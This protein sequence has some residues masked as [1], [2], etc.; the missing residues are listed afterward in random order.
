MK[1]IIWA[2]LILCS[3][4]SST[5]AETREKSQII[6]HS[7]WSGFF[8]GARIAASQST[9]N[10]KNK[11]DDYGAPTLLPSPLDW[12]EISKSSSG[13]VVEKFS[14][15]GL[16]LGYNWQHNSS[17]Y[18]IEADITSVNFSASRGPLINYPIEL[19][20]GIAVSNQVKSNYQASLRGKFGVIKDDFLIF[21]TGGI[22]L[23]NLEYSHE[24]SEFGFEPNYSDNGGSTEEAIRFGWIIGVGSEWRFDQNWSLVTEYLHSRYPSAGA[25]TQWYDPL[26]DAVFSESRVQHS[27]DLKHD[28]LRIGINYN[29]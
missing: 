27:A 13:D 4:T 23:A 16:S 25:S 19:G 29:F 20:G 28:I 7:N 22:A 9:S 8:V 3:V 11:F 21:L 12:L 17:L 2:A 15:I 14:N 6:D 5:F 10:V 18:G 1:P 24:F 26:S